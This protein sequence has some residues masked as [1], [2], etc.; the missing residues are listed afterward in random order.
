MGMTSAIRS[1]AL[2]TSVMST[3]LTRVEQRGLAVTAAPSTAANYGVIRIERRIGEW[4]FCYNIGLID[5]VVSQFSMLLSSR[6][7]AA[8]V[9]D[10]VKLI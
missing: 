7:H 10:D 2:R 8:A 1:K 3:E 5:M 9:L 4:Q 6:I